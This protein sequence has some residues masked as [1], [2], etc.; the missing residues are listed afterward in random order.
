MK[1][2]ILFITFLVISASSFAQGFLPGFDRFS[3]KKTAYITLKDGKKIEGKIKK[4]KRKKG[5]F[6][7]IKIN[8]EGEKIKFSPDDVAN[9]Y[10]PADGLDRFSKKMDFLDNAAT[11]SNMGLN[12]KTISEGYAYFESTETLSGKKKRHLMMQL[13]NPHMGDK[14][15]I[16]F[17]PVAKSTI[18]VGGGIGPSYGGVD[19]SYYYKL[20][21]APA[22]K[23]QKKNYKKEYKNMYADC[24]ELIA[25]LSTKIG[26]MGLA[27][28]VDEYCKCGGKISVQN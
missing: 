2:C 24:P 23:I 15:K 3:G 16:Y 12:M 17:D 19:K 9:M 18:K 25:K 27:K 26:W 13:V 22:I 10:L 8:E 14:M 1:T 4:I 5:S 21:D 11:Y 7:T 28:D 6:K 20:G